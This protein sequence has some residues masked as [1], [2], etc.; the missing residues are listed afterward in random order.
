MK[1]DDLLDEAA[2]ASADAM[3]S[4]DDARTVAVSAIR[5]LEARLID[6][7]A[8][9]TLRGMATLATGFEGT[10]QGARVRGD[11]DKPLPNGFRDVLVL[12]RDGSLVLARKT[13]NGYACRL[14]RDEELLAQDL[15]L[16]V[17]TARTA[18]QRHI[19]C[20]EKTAASY[21]RILGLSATVDAI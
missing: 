9:D 21:G 15:E 8:G 17:Q 5:K 13:A 16:V 10:L 2:K 18:L 3:I 19:A 7:I 11:S 12:K 6:A 20:A 14:V 1:L 4:R